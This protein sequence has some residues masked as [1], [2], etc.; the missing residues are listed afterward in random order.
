MA[1]RGVETI[2]RFAWNPRGNDCHHELSDYRRADIEFIETP[3]PTR[4]HVTAVDG[5]SPG[6][7]LDV[8][9]RLPGCPVA[10][11]ALDLPPTVAGAA[12]ASG[13][14]AVTAFPFDPQGEPSARIVT[15]PTDAVND[16]RLG[17]TAADVLVGRAVAVRVGG[18]L[19]AGRRDHVDIGVVGD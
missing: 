4:P 5:R 15:G 7:R 14:R 10:Q 6:S 11:W 2:S 3:R 9:R 8:S 12:A 19:A 1:R 13:R 18:G 16:A 17:A